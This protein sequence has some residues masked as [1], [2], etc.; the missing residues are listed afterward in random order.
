MNDQQKIDCLNTII[1]ERE[2]ALWLKEVLKD[3]LAYRELAG[4][5]EGLLKDLD[6][7]CSAR[8]A[9]LDGLTKKYKAKEAGLEADLA[10]FRQKMGEAEAVL[11]AHYAD[12]AADI[13]SQLLSLAAALKVAQDKTAKAQDAAVVAQQKQDQ[14]EAA[15]D[16]A[17]Q[18]YEQYKASLK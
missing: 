10:E 3:V 17:I 14:A 4:R 13:D 8:Q 12:A 7:Q 16:K 6:A 15:L 1:N 18:K 11:Q 5:G 2:S 9:D